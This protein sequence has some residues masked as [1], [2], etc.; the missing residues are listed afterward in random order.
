MEAYARLQP[1]VS[2]RINRQRILDWWDEMLRLTGSLKLGYVTASLMVQKFQSYAQQNALAQGLQL[3][4][5][6]PS[7]GDAR[8]F[9]WS[10]FS[11]HNTTQQWYGVVS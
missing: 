5:R 8:I 10:I 6:T 1:Y 4:F 2:G 7:D 9:P 3:T 11:A